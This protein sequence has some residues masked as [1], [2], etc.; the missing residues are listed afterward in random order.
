MPCADRTNGLP[1]RPFTICCP[2][3]RWGFGK[4][5]SESGGIV[6]NPGVIR[7]EPPS[8]AAGVPH[9]INPMPHARDLT[10]EQGKIFDP[11][12]RKPV[13]AV[14]NLTSTTYPKTKPARRHFGKPARMAVVLGMTAKKRS[15]L[16]H[17][18][19]GQGRHACFGTRM[20]RTRWGGSASASRV[21]V[22]PCAG[23]GKAAR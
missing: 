3:S 6:G 1:T 8:K 21:D 19:A 10:D 12:I 11:L 4:P 2:G 5:E 17:G 22:G 18:F 7:R 23:L 16:R 9:C 15:R 13:R 20:V 14:D